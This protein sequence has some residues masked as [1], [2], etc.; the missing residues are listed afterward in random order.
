M[1]LFANVLS[2][3]KN[4]ICHI[5]E[6]FDFLGFR[7]RKYKGKLRGTPFKASIKKFLAAVRSDIK[8]L[9][10][11]SAERVIVTLNPQWCNYYRYVCFSRIFSSIDFKIY[12]SLVQWMHR[13]HIR[14]SRSKA[15]KKYF[16]AVGQRNW[17]FSAEIEQKNQSKM[18]RLYEALSTKY[19]RHDKIR[20]QPHPFDPLFKEYFEKQERKSKNMAGQRRSAL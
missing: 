5:D 1:F 7:I 8:P 18:I 3:E 2:E 16:K 17:V 14:T 20:V 13:R 4:S 10:G 19:K 6:R 9:R 15:L 11:A 12:E